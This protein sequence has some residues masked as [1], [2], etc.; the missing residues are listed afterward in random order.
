MTLLL[1]IDQP[2]RL[3][4]FLR[5]MHRSGEILVTFDQARARR[6]PA[7]SPRVLSQ[8]AERA[9]AW[10]EPGRASFVAAPV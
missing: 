10:S 3:P 4:L 7:P 6:F 2:G 8:I 9:A 1:Q 5:A